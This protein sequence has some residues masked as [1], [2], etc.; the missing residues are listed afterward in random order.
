MIRWTYTRAAHGHYDKGLQDSRR[1]HDPCH[2]QEENHSQDI[3]QA[4]Q[5]DADKRPH[6]W[7]LDRK[8][9]H[10]KRQNEKLY[11]KC[12]L[13]MIVHACNNSAKNIELGI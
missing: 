9:T 3:L 13:K 5:V 1:S 12:M 2:S 11:N 8:T 10:K 6:L 7:T 4:G